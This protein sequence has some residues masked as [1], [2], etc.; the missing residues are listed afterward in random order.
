M[1][2]RVFLSAA[3]LLILGGGPAAADWRQEFRELR[4]GVTSSE[5]ESDTL[6]RWDAF[7]QHMQRKLGVR[8]SVHRGSDYAAV[9]EALHSRRIEFA[10]MGPAA[11]A[12][13]VQ[14]MG[15]NIVPLARDMD[16]DGSVGYHSVVVV[17][18][19]SPFRTLDDLRGRSLAFADPN[20]ASGFQA[21]SYFMTQE[22]KA[23]AS[24]FGRTGF[25]GNHE[26]GVLAVI[27]RQFDGVAT[28]WNNAARSNVTRMEEK[29]MIETG[30]VR[31][32]WTSPMIP[33]SP[34]VMR[35]LPAEL[36]KAYTDAILALPEDAPEVWNRL[37]DSKM[38][39]TVPASAA[40]YVDMVRMIEQNQR[41]RRGP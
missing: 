24:F 21:P 23:P 8:V 41:A 29:K 1:K 27:N 7:A 26:T 33:N 39:K 12:R 15:D 31:V 10:R 17:R 2:R 3:A 22:G 37:V 5:N 30:A 32:V 11:Y 18:A 40:D 19:D 20:S 6:A 35:R 34:W 9:V 14:V 25:A 16:L 36:A 28:W 38:L 13:A 4:F